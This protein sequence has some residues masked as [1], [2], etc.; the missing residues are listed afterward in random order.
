MKQLWQRGPCSGIWARD[1]WGA[2]TTPWVVVPGNTADT[3]LEVERYQ[4]LGVVLRPERC[5]SVRS[6]GLHDENGI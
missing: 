4:A 3:V 5:C 1:V 2:F 6:H